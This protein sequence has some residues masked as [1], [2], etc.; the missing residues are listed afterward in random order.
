MSPARNSGWRRM[1]T[2]RSRLVVTPWIGPGRARRPGR[3][4]PRAGWGRGRSPWPA[5]GRSG[6]AH[7][8]PVLHAAVDP[9]RRSDGRDPEAVQVA[10][11]GLPPTGGVLGVEAGLDG[12]SRR[13][14]ASRTS[15][16]RGRPSATRSCSRTRSSPVTSSV[17]GCSTWSRVFTSRKA[18]VPVGQEQELDGAGVHVADGPGRGHR[19]RAQLGAQRRASRP[20]RGTP[21]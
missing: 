21:R 20:A 6:R 4:P 16:G 5:W 12:V 7:L 13:P 2:S 10:R 18:K 1:R 19:G 11:R 14:R 3:G 17:T 8:G 9:H 15:G